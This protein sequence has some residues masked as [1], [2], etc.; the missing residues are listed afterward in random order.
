MAGTVHYLDPNGDAGSVDYTKV[1]DGVRQPNSGGDDWDEVSGEAGAYS[2]E[3][4]TISENVISVTVWLLAEYQGGD[5]MTVELYVGEPGSGGVG[6]G[7]TTLSSPSGWVSNEWTGLDLSQ[8]DVNDLWVQV[9][10]NAGQTDL[11]V[12]Y[13]AAEE[14]EGTPEAPPAE[15]SLAV[16]IESP[17][18]AQTHVVSPAGLALSLEAASPGL[19]QA[20]TVSPAGIN[21]PVGI[22]S[23]ST[24]YGGQ[25]TITPEGL[26]LAL[27]LESPG[28]TEHWVVSPDSL[29]LPV[30]V[31]TP[32]ATEKITV[33]PEGLDLPLEAGAPGIAQ[34]HIVTPAEMDIGV[35]VGEPYG[36]LEVPLY[37]V[38]TSGGIRLRA[39]GAGELTIDGSFEQSIGAEDRI[40]LGTFE[41]RQ[42][43]EAYDAPVSWLSALATPQDKV[44]LAWAA[45]ADTDEYEIYRRP[46]GGAFALIDTVTS[47]SYVDGPLEDGTYE[48]KV[49]SCADEGGTK[50]SDVA[51][52]TV[53]SAPEP[54]AGISYTFDDDTGTLT[55]TAEASPSADVASYVFRSS[56]GS[57]ELDLDSTP[58]QDSGSLTYTKVFTTETGW[59]I[60]NCRAKDSDGIEEANIARTVAV[61][62]SG[63]SEVG[64]PAAPRIVRA[65]PVSG[66]KVE[67]K[68]FYDP[69]D[70]DPA[71]GG[72][73]Y[74]ARIYW[75]NGS[76]D[77]SFASPHATVS[78]GNPTTAAWHTWTSGALSD[79]T[80][81]AF[82]VRIGTATSPNGE[83][84]TN[85]DEHAA[86]PDSTEPGKPVLSATLT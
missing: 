79:G 37:L 77:V 17:G 74:E 49:R 35:T 78:M 39:G 10:S 12:V 8:S 56:D 4:A 18:T 23:P 61:L 7:S 5:D 16:E 63:G 32:A 2:L 15:L 24:V 52:V 28:V 76:G 1:D 69:A 14:D 30:S 40:R 83:E 48:Y 44:T 58:V 84:T 62:V 57:K 65:E 50:D 3:G 21:L 34:K 20:H 38:G 27:A 60:I 9:A 86:T 55:V 71:S 85:T 6:Q 43:I 45:T 26:N 25:Y 47:T 53:S 67:I 29:A 54:P 59:Y 68:W 64:I 46:S 11:D 81:Y 13:A 51:S 41:P 42:Y 70:E 75:N 19:T 82:V 66:G 33:T 72:A 36:L 31:A 22:G 73:A 80:E